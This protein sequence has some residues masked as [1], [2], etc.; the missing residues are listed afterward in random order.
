MRFVFCRGECGGEW[1]ASA[2]VMSLS[3]FFLSSFFG[4][5]L[6]MKLAGGCRGS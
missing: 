2:W 1:I 3:L 5:F 6:V 4:L